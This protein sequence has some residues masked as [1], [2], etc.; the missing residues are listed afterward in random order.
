VPPVPLLN[1]RPAPPVYRPK[2]TRIVQPNAITPHRTP[3]AAPAMAPPAIQRLIGM[4]PK[5]KL[6]PVKHALRLGSN[7]A[8]GL[9]NSTEKDD[10][11][12]DGDDA[13]TMKRLMKTLVGRLFDV[14]Q[15]IA[16][17]RFHTI[18][19][20]EQP[21]DW[22]VETKRYYNQDWVPMIVTRIRQVGA[23]VGK[24]EAVTHPED[25]QPGVDLATGDYKRFGRLARQGCLPVR[26]DHAIGGQFPGSSYTI[27]E[28]PEWELHKHPGVVRGARAHFKPTQNAGEVGYHDQNKVKD[29]TLI[30]LG[31][32]NEASFR[33]E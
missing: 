25:S 31:T 27:N 3:V 4:I 10:V 7:E 17:L 28:F 11:V 13:K 9:M 23:A 21:P 29:T 6:D 30:M 14:R 19:G 15:R 5:K 12:K 24:L 2:A 33:Q 1:R 32:M 16:Q 18:P 22:L 20:G 26:Y 8:R